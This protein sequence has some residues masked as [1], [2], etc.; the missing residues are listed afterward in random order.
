MGSEEYSIFGMIVV[1]INLGAAFAMFS[2][3]AAFPQ[4]SVLTPDQEAQLREVRTWRKVVDSMSES[5]TTL[6]VISQQLS[7][8]VAQ[9]TVIAT[10][11]EDHQTAILSKIEEIKRC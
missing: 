2:I 3:R 7:Q 1:V 5:T 8:L 4:K 9:Q 6:A 11:S 10:R